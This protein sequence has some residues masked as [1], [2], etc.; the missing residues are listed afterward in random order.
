MALCLN[1]FLMSGGQSFSP[2]SRW[3]SSGLP[4]T[5]IVRNEKR[6]SCK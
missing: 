2:R 1:W 3:R 5:I 4:L 6:K